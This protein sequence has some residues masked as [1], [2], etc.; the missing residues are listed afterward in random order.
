MKL[1]RLI[2]TTIYIELIKDCTVKII[3]MLLYKCK[4]KF[5]VLIKDIYNYSKK[6]FNR[7]LLDP[8]KY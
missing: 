8:K 5:L 6:V 7:E 1:V 2:K 4:L 3:L